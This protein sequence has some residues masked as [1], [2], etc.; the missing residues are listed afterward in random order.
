MA[1]LFASTWGD[2]NANNRVFLVHG[3]S[4]S[5]LSWNHVALDFASRGKLLSTPRKA[6]DYIVSL[7]LVHG[8]RPFFTNDHRYDIVIGHSLGALVVSALLPLLKSSRSVHVVLSDPPLEQSPEQIAHHRETRVHSIRHPKSPDACQQENPLYTREDAIIK[9]MNIHLCDVAALEA[10]F[11][12]NQP[13]SFSHLLSTAP[14]NVKLTV[15]AA[16]PSKDACIREEDLKPYPH[17]TVKTV[18]GSPHTM[19]IAY[20]R[21][22][23]EVA[24]QC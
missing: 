17:V 13:W 11:D 16:D 10:I 22:I 21:D 20:P 4:S 3:I 12:Q 6:H 1:A 7:R 18:W 8:L 5:S 2:P 15:L 14:D 24:L 23:V 19:H 9:S